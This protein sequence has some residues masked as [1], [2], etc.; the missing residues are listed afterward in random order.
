MPNLSKFKPRPSTTAESN[1]LVQRDASG[2]FSAT[3]LATP[4]A[5]NVSGD[6]TGIAQNFDGSRVKKIMY[7]N[8]IV[9]KFYR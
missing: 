2:D 7:G 4:R 3:K 8:S 9:K 6:V 1:T 5:I